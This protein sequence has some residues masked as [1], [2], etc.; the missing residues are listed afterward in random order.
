ME[1]FPSV[2]VY[3][4]VNVHFVGEGVVVLCSGFLNSPLANESLYAS[5]LHKFTKNNQAVICR[6]AVI[7]G[8]HNLLPHNILLQLRCNYFWSST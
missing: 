7:C 4:V 8:F 2:Y 5:R 6:L 1:K 3:N